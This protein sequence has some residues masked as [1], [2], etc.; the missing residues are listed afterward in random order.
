MAD[1][2]ALWSPKNC[3]SEKDYEKSLYTFLHEE[4]GNV[5][6]TKQF[7]KGRM[8]ADIVV[9]DEV[10]W[11]LKHDLDT[12]AKLQR[13]VGQQ[14]RTYKEWDGPVIVLLTGTTEPNIRKQLARLIRELSDESVDLLEAMNPMNMFATSGRFRVLEK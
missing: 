8:K 9:G 6:V 7:S 14:L 3:K 11:E 10:I 1:L 12:T 2:I 13:L 4:L 5:Q